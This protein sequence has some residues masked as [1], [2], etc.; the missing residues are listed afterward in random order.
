MVSSSVSFPLRMLCFML[1][2]VVVVI[3]LVIVVD[4]NR[5]RKETKRRALRFTW[6]CYL[7]YV[8]F[9]SSWLDLTLILIESTFTWYAIYY[10]FNVLLRLSGIMVVVENEY[11]PHRVLHLALAITWLIHWIFIALINFVLFL[12]L[13][14]FRW[15]IV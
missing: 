11:I 13:L 2:I 9:T 6:L 5:K 1:C 7:V 10:L 15:K 3:A 14:F 12:G 8:D 4:E